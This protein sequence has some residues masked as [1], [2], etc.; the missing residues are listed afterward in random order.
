M[1]RRVDRLTP[2]NGILY[3]PS[4]CLFPE[5]IESRWQQPLHWVS[6]SERQIQRRRVVLRQT[7]LW[8][9]VGKWQVMVHFQLHKTVRLVPASDVS[10]DAFDPAHAPLPLLSLSL[11]LL[12]LCR[13]GRIAL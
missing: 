8:N 10:G 5:G 12:S 4:T 7:E 13:A 11:I 6:Q 3:T 2:E 9:R 1:L